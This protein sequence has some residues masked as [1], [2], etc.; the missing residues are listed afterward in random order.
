MRVVNQKTNQRCRE[1][2][3][4]QSFCWLCSRQEVEREKAGSNRRN[5]GC[6]SVHVVKQIDRIRDSYQPEDREYEVDWGEPAPGKRQPVVNNKSRPH[7]LAD[8]FLIGLGVKQ[9]IDESNQKQKRTRA[10]YHPAMWGVWSEEEQRDYHGQPDGHTSHHRCWLLMP[11]IRLRPRH[12][13]PTAVA[14]AYNRRPQPRDYK[15]HR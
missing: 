4:H 8:E 9:I 2:S 12:Q 11:A 6:Q 7:D 3:Q 13:T 10:N 1:Y 14:R 5:A 15:N